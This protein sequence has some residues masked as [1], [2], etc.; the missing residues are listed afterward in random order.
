MMAHSAATGVK[1]W[2]VDQRRG[3]T[4]T[5]R[6]L[7]L[8][9]AAGSGKTAVLAERCA[10]LVAD[11]KPPCRV[12]QLLVVTFTEAAAAEM[13]SRIRQAL[14]DRAE[15]NP[16]PYLERQLALIEHAQ[17]STLHQFCSRLLR[18]HFHL[19]GLDPHF[20]ILDEDE[21][22]LLRAETVRGLFADGYEG[23]L[24]DRDICP[25]EFHNLIDCYGDGNDATL[26]R[27][28]LR[29]HDLLC[30]LVDPQAWRDEALRRIREAGEGPL[31]DS[32]LG[33]EL[34]QMI[35]Q[36]LCAMRQRCEQTEARL[37]RM[38]GF[39]RYVVQLRE[40]WS[41]LRHWEK[42]F[43]EHGLSALAEEV[44]VDL[45][46]LPS[47]SNSVPGKE[48]A[49]AMMDAVRKPMKEGMLFDMM[50]FTPEQWREGM[51]AT[52]PH[53][54]VCLRLVE[55]FDERYRQEKQ[56]MRA[57]DFSDLE[58]YALRVLRDESRPGLHPSAVA[59][60]CHR[61]FEHVLV[62]E[63]Q[64]IN[65]VQDAILTL[66]SR[67]CLW[68][69]GSGVG[70]QDSAESAVLDS[71]SR[72]LNPANLFC[73]GDVKQSI[74]RFR[75][76]EPGRFLD[77]QRR[78]RKPGRDRFG[79]VIDLQ[80]NFRSRAPLL[81][82]INNVFERMMTE[83]AAEIAYDDVHW[84]HAGLAY[85]PA[86][87]TACFSGAPVEMH[88]LPDDVEP[89]SDDDQDVAPGAVTGGGDAVAEME[90]AEREAL[91]AARLIRRMTGL[92][93]SPPMHVMDRS[94]GGLHPRPIR[95]SDIVILLRA[96][97]F[98]AEQYAEILRGHGIPVHS[99]G[100]TGYFASMEVRDMLA[101]LHLLD[102]QRQDIPMAAVLRSPLS[103]LE[104]PDDAMARIRLAC[105]GSADPVPFHEAVIRYA[106]E[107]RDDLAQWL[108]QF[109]QRVSEWR[110][111][112]QRR[113]L[114]DVIWTIYEQI[115]YLAFVSGL[116]NGEQRI[117][118]LMNLH[119]RAR[120]FGTFQRQGL[121]RFLQFLS[122]L[123]EQSDLGQ[124][125]V[126]SQAEDVVRIM[127]VH[128]SKGLEF[129]VVLM[130]DLGKK[131]NMSDTRGNILVDRHAYLGMTVADEKK[132][133]RY[134]SLAWMLAAERMKGQCL[135]EE[136]RVLYVAM[137]RAREHLVLIGTCR[138]D[139]SDGWIG[140]W[141]GYDGPLPGD[142]VLAG[143]CMLDW[144]GPVAAMAD[145][146][147][148]ISIH[149]HTAD[150]V[151][152][153]QGAEQ[154]HGR[155]ARASDRGAGEAPVPLRN[156]PQLDLLDLRP[157]QPPPP[158]H[159]AAQDVIERLTFNY[160]HRALSS[161][162]AA[163]SVTGW[164]KHGRAAPV[165][166]DSEDGEM[167]FKAVLEAPRALA[168]EP[169]AT[170]AER[171]S[172]THLLLQHLDFSGPC[173]SSDLVRQVREMVCRRIITSEQATAVDLEAVKWLL[174]TA[175]GELLRRHHHML[176]RELPFNLAVDPAEMNTDAAAVE[177]LDRMMV[178]GRIDVL[179]PAEEGLV[180][181]DYKT[182]RVTHDRVDERAAFYQPQVGL[183]RRAV[184]TILKRPVAAVHLVFLTPR[185]IRTS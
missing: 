86:D 1:Q 170:A 47:I 89:A 59:R 8:S 161:V 54:R 155:P 112:A 70:D 14:Q 76:A 173:N 67:E 149:A 125:S 83:Q 71:E 181:V 157:L 169:K 75:L 19:L 139:S 167:S 24:A 101:L 114:A 80:K 82:A 116:P 61:R 165:G 88:L 44:Q 118:N 124:P 132:R 121:A 123:Q 119:E 176:R 150:E 137:T 27:A 107:Q 122:N 126:S 43:E 174:G 184:E 133:I 134:P 73:V 130:P 160:P 141:N 111:L 127:T 34:Q 15:Q 11:A 50:R 153:W 93:G 90:R 4:T 81:N 179:V 45:P 18:Q 72:I 168:T 40:L 9:A 20:T 135:A 12:D 46:R 175:T 60:L 33:R 79:E 41:I 129:P 108:G 38:K 37:T 25:T 171:G 39:D 31:E 13:K 163:Q 32:T 10:H 128:G 95:F 64:D 148:C 17:V 94:P 84:L 69:A 56:R 62:D 109:L 2:T 154:W 77:R 115:G 85:P 140:R 58:R 105:R 63:Y 98:K 26:E 91:L 51:T 21:A 7:L 159:P 117:A 36:Q 138:P 16:D 156:A 180:L 166:Y 6:S 152:N 146:S 147:C 164:T 183:Y 92:D 143:R 22:K 65:E 113:P 55:Q 52:L 136:M 103:S 104:R 68:S 5:G 172:T 49:K 145:P 30:S 144:L 102:N 106:T 99:D 131:I 178:R 151:R 158:M 96:M 57:L 100:R 29:A 48:T 87:G 78:F 42:T 66:A 35:R 110:E 182:D 177:P 53:A 120:Q 28:V 142:Q 162:P 23:T 185:I 97:Q 74:Y 3:I